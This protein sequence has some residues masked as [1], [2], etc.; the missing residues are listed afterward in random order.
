MRW[1]DE[2][3]INVV[4]FIATFFARKKPS[5]LRKRGAA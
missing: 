5:S 1:L 2:L 4:G 3:F